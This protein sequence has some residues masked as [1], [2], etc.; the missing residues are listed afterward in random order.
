MRRSS[1]AILVILLFVTP[2]IWIIRHLSQPTP[3]LHR[4]AYE[5]V[6]M[7]D[8]DGDWD[9]YLWD[10]RGDLHNLTDTSR[11]HEYFP[12]F[13]F[14]GDQIRM[15]STALGEVTTARVNADGSDF[16]ALT[17]QE[18]ALDVLSGGNF[19]FD[20]VWNSGGTRMAWYRVVIVEV[21]DNRG[22]QDGAGRKHSDDFDYLYKQEDCAVDI[23]QPR[24]DSAV[25]E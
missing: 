8:R 4:V 22:C 1:L 13:S 18:A 16:K 6:F 14:D 3:E 5:L 2:G 25:S 15:Y 10:A 12:G 19:D 24:H 11:A 23:H 17:L 20:P 9:V 21:R 7:S